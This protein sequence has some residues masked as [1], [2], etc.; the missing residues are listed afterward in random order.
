MHNLTVTNINIQGINQ[1]K[2]DAISYSEAYNTNV[3]CLTETHL[4]EQSDVSYLKL[5]GYHP[6]IRRDRIGQLGGGVAIFVASHLF[7]KR[8]KIITDPNDLEVL[9]VEL[10]LNKLKLCLGVCYRPPNTNVSF[11]DK[12]HS[13]V[14]N[15]YKHSFLELFCVVILM[16]IL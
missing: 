5:D 10:R 8:I 15:I 9:W 7:Y 12:L 16:L 3:I 13:S 11:W 14:G 1:T 2:L 4:H 6:I